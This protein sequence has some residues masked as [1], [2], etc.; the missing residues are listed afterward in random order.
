MCPSKPGKRQKGRCFGEKKYVGVSCFP[1][2]WF[3]L[4]VVGLLWV[5]YA[6]HAHTD[7]SSRGLCDPTHFRVDTIGSGRFVICVMTTVF[8]ELLWGLGT[9]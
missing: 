9:S 6:L 5:D 7:W 1:L 4:R 2:A 3:W 8:S